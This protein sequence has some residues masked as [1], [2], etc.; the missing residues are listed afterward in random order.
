M[1]QEGGEENIKKCLQF[2]PEAVQQ[3]D[4]K[5]EPVLPTI[6]V[7]KLVDIRVQNE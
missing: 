6:K 4:P 1:L 5:V 7:G 3:R 2:T